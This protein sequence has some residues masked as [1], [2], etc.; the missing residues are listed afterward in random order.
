MLP[1][2]FFIRTISHSDFVAIKLGNVNSALNGLLSEMWLLQATWYVYTGYKLVPVLYSL[3]HCLS[4]DP[5]IS[6]KLACNFLSYLTA[7]N[8]GCKIYHVR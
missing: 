2:K 4:I 1:T 6:S 7:V 3:Q 8:Y 5:K